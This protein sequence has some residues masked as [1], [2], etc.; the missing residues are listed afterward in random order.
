MFSAVVPVSVPSAAATRASSTFTLAV[1]VS[2]WPLVEVKRIGE[3]A[4]V[5]QL[6]RYQERLDLDSRLAQCTNRRQPTRHCGLRLTTLQKQ[7]RVR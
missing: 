1:N 5:D 7:V 3:I 4:G 6:L 2:V